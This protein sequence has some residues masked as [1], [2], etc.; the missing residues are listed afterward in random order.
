M[1]NKRSNGVREARRTKVAKEEFSDYCTALFGALFPLYFALLTNEYPETKEHLRNMLEAI[2]S[3][4]I[5]IQSVLDNTDSTARLVLFRNMVC[6]F[7]V[8]RCRSTGGID[9]GM[10]ED[11]T[12]R[13]EVKLNVRA[14]ETNLDTPIKRAYRPDG[15]TLTPI[16]GS[17]QKTPASVAK[18]RLMCDDFDLLMDMDINNLAEDDRSAHPLATATPVRDAQKL[19]SDSGIH[20][21]T[22]N[23]SPPQ[24]GTILFVGSDGVSMPLPRLKRKN[25]DFCLTTN[26]NLTEVAADIRLKKMEEDGVEVKPLVDNTEADVKHVRLKAHEYI[27]RSFFTG[28]WFDIKPDGVEFP[29]Y[30]LVTEELCLDP[31]LLFRAVWEHHLREGVHFS[32]ALLRWDFG[33][34]ATRHGLVTVDTNAEHLMFMYYM[35]YLRPIFDS[36]FSQ[37]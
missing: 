12:A 14:K 18:N 35:R 15:T 10:C 37:K 31:Y 17:M 8:S 29:R 34:L 11:M 22:P 13:M 7:I 33:T 26:A 30:P 4:T 9:Q 5:S 32:T 25:Y 27:S 6:H 36:L 1:L 20:K 3:A 16:R 28:T 19:G 23:I 21:S 2:G 24:T